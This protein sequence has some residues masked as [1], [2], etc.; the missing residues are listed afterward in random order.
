VKFYRY[1]T[2]VQASTDHNGEYVNSTV[3][4]PVLVVRE[5]NLYKETPKGYWIGFGTPET[6]H[7]GKRWVSKTGKKRYAYPTKEEA[8]HNFIRRK[9]KQ[10]QITKYILELAQAA[11]T[12]GIEEQRKQQSIV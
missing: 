11:L 12:L 2:Y 5:M 7:G 3:P 1:E 8:L 10:I 9:K 4:F 6:L